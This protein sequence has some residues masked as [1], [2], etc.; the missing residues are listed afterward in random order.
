[1]EP[2]WNAEAGHGAKGNGKKTLGVTVIRDDG[3][4]TSVL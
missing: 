1:M 4:K 2:G 3:N